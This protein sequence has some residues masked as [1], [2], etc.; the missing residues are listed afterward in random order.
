MHVLAV[1]GVGSLAG[2]RLSGWAQSVWLTPEG[3]DPAPYNW[4]SFWLLQCAMSLAAAV[5]LVAFFSEAPPHADGDA[6]RSPE[7]DHAAD[8]SELAAAEANN[9]TA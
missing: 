6:N 3:V 8:P 7:Q 4:Q 1:F 5:V 2:A 9:P